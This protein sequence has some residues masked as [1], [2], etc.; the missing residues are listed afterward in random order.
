MA[1]KTQEQIDREYQAKA[2]EREK[3]SYTYG[4]YSGLAQYFSDSDVPIIPRG[5]GQEKLAMVESRESALRLHEQKV[6]ELERIDESII[7]R[8][9]ENIQYAD[10]ERQMIASG[11]TSEGG[12]AGTGLETV[13]DIN[14]AIG[15]REIEDMRAHQE[16]VD[17]AYSSAIRSTIRGGKYRAEFESEMERLR[18]DERKRQKKGGIIQFAGTTIGATLGFVGSGFNPAG[19]VAGAKIGHSLTSSLR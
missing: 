12:V 13:Q 18:E 9:S 11:G 4:E 8:I 10:A 17:R 2:A 5:E 16:N 3:R 6:A 19:A 1:K 7:D 15:D 14:R